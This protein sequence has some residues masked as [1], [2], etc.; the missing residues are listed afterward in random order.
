MIYEK[1]LLLSDE[2][3]SLASNYSNTPKLSSYA[4]FSDNFMPRSAPFYLQEHVAF[5]STTDAG[6]AEMNQAIEHLELM[7]TS[8][9]RPRLVLDLCQCTL[10][11][12]LYKY[13]GREYLMGP[14]KVLIDDIIGWIEDPEIDE[15]FWANSTENSELQ[16]H[17]RSEMNHHVYY[18]GGESPIRVVTFSTHDKPELRQLLKS[19][20]FAGVPIDVVGIGSDFKKWG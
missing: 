16:E 8:K 7:I 15:Q 17:I 20:E 13:K 18:A 6:I 14:K 9:K 19:G 4:F 5:Y 10:A 1:E 12:L 3:S 2:T 11:N